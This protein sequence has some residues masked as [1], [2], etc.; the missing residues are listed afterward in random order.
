MKALP[1]KSARAVLA[2]TA[3][4][5]VLAGCSGSG[6]GTS[7]SSGP[8]PATGPPISVGFM[9]V[10]SGTLAFP[11]V[12]A[13]AKAA[14]DWVNGHGGIGGR[15]LK[16]EICSTDGST[17]T[18]TKCANELI[19]KKV[20]AVLNGNAA[21]DPALPI[22]K[23]AALHIFGVSGSPAV[24]GDPGNTLMAV[25]PA[26][27]TAAIGPVHRAMGINNG[28]YVLPNLGPEIKKVFGGIKTAAAASDLQLTL[29]V[30]APVNPDFTAAVNAAR[31]TDA[32]GLMFSFAENDCTNAVRTAKSMNWDGELA[33]GQCNQFVRDLGPQAAGVTSTVEL[34]PFSARASAEKYD[35]HL[36]EEFDEY[37]AA[38][39]AAGAEEYLGYGYATWG[40]STVM[41]FADILKGIDGDV[42]KTSAEH[43]IG[44]FK[45]RQVLGTPKDC[46][47]KLMPGANC[48]RHLILL[49]S[50]ADGT[51]TLVG[52]KPLD[53]GAVVGEK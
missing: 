24:S 53:L 39:Q 14:A 51:Q 27:A 8:D 38:V 43:A 23:K 35:S 46:R 31:T 34:F 18:T 17:A 42:T 48:G 20:L 30:V 32:D 44:A 15:P 47:A 4:A 36:K 37:E 41:T 29:S 26:A 21:L 52:G 33:V 40:Y 1:L 6:A 2:L 16:L 5:T 19:G 25:P 28:V 9:N 3:V 13:T 22:F 11:E 49:E 7:T 50:H 10:D 45:G 12:T